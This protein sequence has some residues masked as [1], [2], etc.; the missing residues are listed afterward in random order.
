MAT[1][2]QQPM[3]LPQIAIV[4]INNYDNKATAIA[5][6]Q[7]LDASLARSDPSM[8]VA[9]FWVF[10]NTIASRFIEQTWDRIQKNKWPIVRI[11]C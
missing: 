4:D 7:G 11:V 1:T 2:A 5:Q 10:D 3:S 8:R 9:Y 6:F